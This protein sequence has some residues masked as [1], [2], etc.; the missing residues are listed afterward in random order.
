MVS[1]LKCENGKMGMG[2]VKMGKGSAL[3]NWYCK[4]DGH[5]AR[6]ENTASEIN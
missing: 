6:G 3:Q 4:L 2:M 1:M 5:C